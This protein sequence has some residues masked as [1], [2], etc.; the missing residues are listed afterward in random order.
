ML[1]EEC[2][3]LLSLTGKYLQQWGTH[4]ISNISLAAKLLGYNNKF[5]EVILSPLCIN[6]WKQDA[7]LIFEINAN[8]KIQYLLCWKGQVI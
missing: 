7:F 6:K 1:K 2:F 3:Y 8:L 5:I 4:W